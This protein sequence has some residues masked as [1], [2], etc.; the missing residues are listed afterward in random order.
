MSAKRVETTARAVANYIVWRCQ[1]H[2]DSITNLKLQKL[3]YYAQGWFLALHERP[4]FRDPLRAWVRG[5]V[6]YE[7]WKVFNEFKWRPITKQ[8]SKPK[9]S[10]LAQDH[11]DEVIEVFGDYGAYT[12]E[13]MTHRERPWLRARGDLASDASSS[14]I[15]SL[16]DMRAY[17]S[18]IANEPAQ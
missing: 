14:N 2:G 10:E 17:F 12:L 11:L 5:P 7:V 13:R 9:L 16:D 3:L 1:R 4:L 18:E 6:Q 8:V 15:I